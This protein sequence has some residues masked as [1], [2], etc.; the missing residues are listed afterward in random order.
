MKKDNRIC[1][2]DYES[3]MHYDCAECPVHDC[4]YRKDVK[5]PVMFFSVLS[6]IVLAI[7]AFVVL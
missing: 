6:I 5:I 2:G 3:A 1:R 4:G 7:L